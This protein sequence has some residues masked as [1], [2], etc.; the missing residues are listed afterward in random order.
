MPETVMC[1]L[2]NG[3]KLILGIWYG[4]HAFALHDREPLMLAPGVNVLNADDAAYWRSWKADHRESPLLTDR[5]V[6][7]I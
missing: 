5:F 3:L 1:R 7:E 6:Y 2:N 4:A